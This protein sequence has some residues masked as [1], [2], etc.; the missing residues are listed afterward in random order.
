MHD[1]VQRRNI[2]VLKAGKK[3]KGRYCKQ[4][5]RNVSGIEVIRRAGPS[6]IYSSRVLPVAHWTLNTYSF[7]SKSV[8]E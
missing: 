1:F 2:G 3:V 8:S 6:L 7:N 5:P 4:K